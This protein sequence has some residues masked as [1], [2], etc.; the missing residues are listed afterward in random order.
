MNKHVYLYVQFRENEE[1]EDISIHEKEASRNVLSPVQTE[2]SL[3]LSNEIKPFK[4]KI[5]RNGLHG[6]IYTVKF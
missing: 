4:Q 6:E 3:E 5:S 2:D 1:D